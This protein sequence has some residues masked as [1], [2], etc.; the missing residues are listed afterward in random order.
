MDFIDGAA[1]ESFRGEVS[2]FLTGAWQPDERC[3]PDLTEFVN[4]AGHDPDGDGIQCF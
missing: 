4:G 1:A 2:A 3:G